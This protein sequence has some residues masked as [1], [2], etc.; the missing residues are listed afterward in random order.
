MSKRPTVSVSSR[1]RESEMTTVA[2]FTQDDE[3]FWPI[4]G[5]VAVVAVLFGSFLIWKLCLQDAIRKRFAS[6]SDVKDE[7]KDDDK[8]EN[9]NPDSET[10]EVV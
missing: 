3:E 9:A 7:E 5:V 10:A 1:Q 6:S 2:T 4:V 8:K